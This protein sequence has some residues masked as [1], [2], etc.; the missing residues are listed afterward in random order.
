M[1]GGDWPV[2]TLAGTYREWYQFTRRFT[3]GWSTAERDAFY[4]GNA[5]RCYDLQVN[6]HEATQLSMK[7]KQ[8][9]AIP[10]VPDA[11]PL[12]PTDEGEVAAEFQ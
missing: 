3:G 8:V 12:L 2:L 1:Y 6:H 10:L 9:D 4:G 11:Q 5:L 7:E